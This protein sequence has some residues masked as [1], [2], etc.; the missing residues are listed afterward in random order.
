M[1]LGLWKSMMYRSIKTSKILILC[2]TQD[3]TTYASHVLTL[4]SSPIG[5][6]A[7]LWTGLRSVLSWSWYERWIIGMIHMQLPFT[8][9]DTSLAISHVLKTSSSVLLWI[10][11]IQNAFEARV[12]RVTPNNHMEHQIGVIVYLK[13]AD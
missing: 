8:S 10:R 13:K 4:R 11:D 5:K 6:D 12:Q 3:H 2:T 7:W 1:S 9:M